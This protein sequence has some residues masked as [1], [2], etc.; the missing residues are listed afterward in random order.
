MKRSVFVASAVATVATGRGRSAMAKAADRNVVLTASDGVQVYGIKREPSTSPI[1]IIL[2]FH[3]ASSSADEYDPIAPRLVEMG[4]ATL[5]IDQRSGGSLYGKNRTVAELG[6]SES[7]LAAERDLDAAT[8]WAQK[9]YPKL[10]I[11]LWGSSY[12]ASLVF[13][14]AANRRGEIARVLAF[15]PGEYFEGKLEVAKVARRVTAPIFV[16]SAADKEEI[17]GAKA[18]LAA[19]PSTVKIQYVPKHGVHGSSTLRKD[20]DPD[21]YDENWQAVEAFLRRPLV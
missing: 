8:A 15:S 6:R 1:G 20:K 18:I 4:Y 16:D 17:E 3:Q 19:S 13:V 12:S 7:Y 5:A 10:P 14:T 2:L 9:T 21:G 11:I